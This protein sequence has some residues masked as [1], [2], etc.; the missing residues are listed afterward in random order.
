MAPDGCVALRKL[1]EAARGHVPFKLILLD[2]EMP[3][4]DGF[5]LAEQMKQS[6]ALSGAAI[7]MLTSARTLGNAARC[8]NLGVFCH[9]TKPA[10]RSTLVEAI[11]LALNE[12]SSARLCRTHRGV[13]EP[14]SASGLRILLAEDHLVVMLKSARPARACCVSTLSQRATLSP[15]TCL[16]REPVEACSN[17]L[18][19]A[20]Y[21]CMSFLHSGWC[22]DDNGRPGKTPLSQWRTA[23]CCG[24][25]ILSPQEK[26]IF[27]AK[28]RMRLC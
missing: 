15:V 25:R 1:E 26:S 16:S 23:S 5:T 28:E 24:F 4:L 19:A 6:A 9:L 22:C 17:S 7:V 11:R 27:S 10:M 2:S 20:S 12:S 3:D 18:R 8:R 14:C 21:S 13:P